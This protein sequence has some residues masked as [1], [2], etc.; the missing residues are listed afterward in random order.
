MI[1][2]HLIMYERLEI[3]F[4][5]NCCMILLCCMKEARSI[6]FWK[7]LRRKLCKIVFERSR[8]C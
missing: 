4:G 2:C 1:I 8:V 3:A 5:T 7:C 6:F